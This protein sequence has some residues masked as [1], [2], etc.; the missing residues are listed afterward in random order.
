[1]SIKVTIFKQTYPKFWK[2]GECLYDRILVQNAITFCTFI[3]YAY[4]NSA[5]KYDM[6]LNK[7]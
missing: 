7:R 3:L 2:R 4:R 6:S 1:M 5:K